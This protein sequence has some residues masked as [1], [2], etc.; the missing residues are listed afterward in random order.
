MTEALELY[1]KQ[2]SEPAGYL[3][4]ASVGPPSQKVV[5]DVSQR[6]AESARAGEPAEDPIGRTL[7]GL[8][9]LTGLPE[10]S[11]CM[12]PST[13]HGLSQIA[14]GMPRGEIIV[15]TSEFPA[16]LYPWWQE[17]RRGRLS[18]RPL[19][20]GRG[21]YLPVTPERVAAALTPRTVGVSV[22]AVD[23]RTGFR[24]D[25]T[26]IREAIGDDVLLIVDA[27]QAFGAVEMPWASADV[28]VS[29][30]QKWLR[31]GSGTAFARLSERAQSVLTPA[32]GWAGVERSREFDG[33]PHEPL[34]GAAR[35]LVTNPSPLLGTALASALDVLEIL[36]AGEVERVIGSSVTHL[37]ASLADRS[38]GVASPTEPQHRAGIVVVTPSDPREAFARAQVAG[39]TTTFHDPDRIRISV[40]ATTT[41]AA[42]DELVECLDPR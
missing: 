24:A 35:L 26:G 9:R 23:F 37:L 16:N 11:F 36:G 41:A 1:R 18:V 19:P 33:A 31:A 22:S 32:T 42:L 12:V 14:A 7:A 34:A 10:S 15:S 39:F 27:I 6:L 4:F 8:H 21:S 40:H 5:D 3:N 38:I 13:S 20:A 30:G 29:G 28:V 25:L 2:F 17:Q